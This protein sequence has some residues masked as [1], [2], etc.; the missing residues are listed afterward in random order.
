MKKVESK[1][2]KKI[3]TYF[4]PESSTIFAKSVALK[5]LAVNNGAKS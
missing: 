4:A 3:L 2:R 5:Y 1:K